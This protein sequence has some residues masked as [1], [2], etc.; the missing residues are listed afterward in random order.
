MDNSSAV[1]LLAAL[2]QESRLAVFRLL[3]QQGPAGLAAGQISASLGIAPNT[4]TFHLK[5]LTH[6]GLLSSRPAGRF[7]FYAVNFSVMSGLMAF[8]VDNCCQGEGCL[9][10]LSPLCGP[11]KARC[12]T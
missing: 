12:G 7:V 3:V 10:E 2:A 6:A 4:L 1:I 9:P 8:L 11:E 5:E